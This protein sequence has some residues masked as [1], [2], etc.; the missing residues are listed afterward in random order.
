MAKKEFKNWAYVE[1][2]VKENGT[3]EYRLVRVDRYDR[4]TWGVYTNIYELSDE[5]QYLKSHGI[6]MG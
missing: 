4:W 2:N 5:I 6:V 1:T 3:I